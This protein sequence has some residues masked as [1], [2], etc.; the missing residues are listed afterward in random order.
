MA[1]IKVWLTKS[2][3]GY[4]CVGCVDGKAPGLEVMLLSMPLLLLLLAKYNG[5]GIKGGT[6][7]LL[8]FSDDSEVDDMIP[9]NLLLLPVMD[10]APRCLLARATVASV[11][12]A[13]IRSSK[14]WLALC[15][16][17]RLSKV[18]FSSRTKG[19]G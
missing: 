7:L 15:I 18:Y 14:D 16:C 2:D 8:L 17:F 5:I 3:D 12:A 13:D 19:T 10:P 4:K 1:A 11:A 9:S 6:W